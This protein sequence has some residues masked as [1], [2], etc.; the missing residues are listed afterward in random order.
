MKALKTLRARALFGIIASSLC[1][2]IAFATDSILKAFTLKAQS[3]IGFNVKKF[4][5]VN[6]QGEFKQ[7]SGSLHLEGENIVALNGEIIIKSVFSDSEKRD[8][9]IL[10]ADFLDEATFPKGYFV[11]SSYTPTSRTDKAIFGK[12][13]GE[14]TLKGVKQ[15]VIFSSALENVESNSPKLSLESEIN[16]KDFGIEGSAMNSNSVKISLTTIWEQQ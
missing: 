16:I 8:S 10:A 11:M 15:K 5:F 1:V 7:K 13:S 3:H 14:L 6:V 2:N 9:H 12:V 4:G